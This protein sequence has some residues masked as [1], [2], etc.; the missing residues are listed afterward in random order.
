[1]I[2][3]G[4]GYQRFDVYVPKNQKQFQKKLVSHMINNKESLEWVVQ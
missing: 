1:M 2:L 3:V 4:G